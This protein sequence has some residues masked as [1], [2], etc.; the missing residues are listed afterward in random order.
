MVK[1]K[2]VL[3]GAEV[4]KEIEADSGYITAAAT[5]SNYKKAKGLK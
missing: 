5:V 1:V 2:K 3:G 4:V